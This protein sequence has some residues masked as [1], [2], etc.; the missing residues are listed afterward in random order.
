[1]PRDR[2]NRHLTDLR[3]TTVVNALLRAADLTLVAV[4]LTL[5]AFAL[6]L[7]G[8]SSYVA[9]SQTDVPWTAPLFGVAYLAAGTWLLVVVGQAFVRRWDR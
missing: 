7:A 4:R 1:M 3:E 9:L 6:A 5:L 8:Y 2:M